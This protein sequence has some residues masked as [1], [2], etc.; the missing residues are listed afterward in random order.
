MPLSS[1]RDVSTQSTR[2]FR[3]PRRSRA[4][5]ALVAAV[6]LSVAAGTAAPAL[7]TGPARVAGPQRGTLVSAVELEG[8]DVAQATAY[9]KDIGFV[10]PDAAKNGVDV[11]RITYR[12]ITATGRPTVAS[13][14]V[15]LPRAASGHGPRRLST[16]S[17]THGTLA[18]RGGAGSV[19][20]GADRAVTVMF[21]GAGFAAVAPDYL[22]LG[23]GTGP[24][25][26]MDIGSETTAS[27]DMLKAARAFE[28]EK[29]VIADGKV[30]VTGFSQGAAAAMGLGRALQRE[31]VPGLRL[32]ALAPV[33]GPYDLS[34]AEIPA[35]FDGR[36]APRTATFYLAYVITAW[37]RLHPLYSS[38]AEAFRAPYAN[39][40]PGLFDGS[41]PDEEIA[42]GLPGTPEELLTPRFIERLKHPRGVLARILRTD[43]AVC[44]DW[45]PHAPV[46]LYDGNLDTDVALANT[47]SCRHA[48]AANGVDAP[49]VNAGNVDHTGSALVSYPKILQWFRGLTNRR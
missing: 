21:A 16:V 15:T 12:T 41:H 40:V 49:V 23:L 35:A 24:H 25:P 38:A 9:V 10:A 13:G 32:T 47:L 46:R 18:Y 3:S 42:A 33:S 6:C 30:M 14:L 29:G 27:V 17:Y 34:G 1:R 5:A 31:A 20:D 7:A 45:A 4:R 2:P 22:G 19:A 37:N 8:M 39:T 43:D 28:A 36:L 44:T 11:Y 26:Y 48:L